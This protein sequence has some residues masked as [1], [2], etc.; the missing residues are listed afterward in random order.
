MVLHG[1]KDG[2]GTPWQIRVDEAPMRRPPEGAIDC[3]FD[4]VVPPAWVPPRSPVSL[5]VCVAAVKGPGADPRQGTERR[6]IEGKGAAPSK[7]MIGLI[8]V[9]LTKKRRF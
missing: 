6:Q 4:F 5:G 8:A 9:R 2:S 7:E 3:D 1:G